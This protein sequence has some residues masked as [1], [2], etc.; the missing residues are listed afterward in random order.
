MQVRHTTCFS[1]DYGT[2]DVAF[3]LHQDR[4]GERVIKKTRLSGWH[5]QNASTATLAPAHS[6][7]IKL[8]SHDE[9]DHGRI[10]RAKHVIR[11]APQP[12]FAQWGRISVYLCKDPQ[13]CFGPRFASHIALTEGPS[14]EWVT[15]SHVIR[16]PPASIAIWFIVWIQL[17][18]QIQVAGMHIPYSSTTPKRQVSR[19]SGERGLG[20]HLFNWFDSSTMTVSRLSVKIGLGCHFFFFFKLAPAIFFPFLNTEETDRER[21][22]CVRDDVRPWHDALIQH[23]TTHFLWLR[24]DRLRESERHKRPNTRA[25]KRTHKTWKESFFFFLRHSPETNQSFL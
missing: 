3:T 8:Y 23:D 21:A 11:T 2:S 15:Y 17:R 4:Q 20:Y 10:R 14:R 24:S 18:V 25:F 7:W 16:N 9:R 1:E 13:L 12:E 6:L 22:R 5:N 19:L